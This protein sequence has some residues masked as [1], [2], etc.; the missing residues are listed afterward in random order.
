[1]VSLVIPASIET[2]RSSK[3]AQSISRSF[4]EARQMQADRILKP[5]AETPSNRAGA[6]APTEWPN[7][8]RAGMSPITFTA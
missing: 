4:N 2:S 6:P 1:M 5:S 3:F 8:P 7:F